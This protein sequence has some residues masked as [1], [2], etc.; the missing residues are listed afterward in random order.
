MHV[1]GGRGQEADPRVPG[2]A[3]C[4]EDSDEDEL[5]H[6][7]LSRNKGED[8]SGTTNGTRFGVP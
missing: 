4:G 7:A 3:V 1:E 5:F 2:V 6:S 8:M